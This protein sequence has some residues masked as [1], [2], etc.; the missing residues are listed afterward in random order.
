MGERWRSLARIWASLLLIAV[1]VVL[2]YTGVATPTEVGALGAFAS[3]AIGFTLGRLSWAGAVEAVR[4]TIK[5]SAL[6]FMILIGATLF[7]YYM[8]ISQIPQ[9]VV[10]AVTA[11]DLNRWVVIIAI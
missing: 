9:H 5:T 3:A 4:Q 1:V 6:I 2:L 11:L 7:G 10:A 8:A